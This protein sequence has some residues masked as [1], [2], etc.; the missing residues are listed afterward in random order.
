MQLTRAQAETTRVHFQ[1]V[2]SRPGKRTLL[3]QFTT[4]KAAYAFIAAKK[5][6]GVDW[7]LY[8]NARTVS[9]HFAT[10]ATRLVASSF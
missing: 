5:G 6:R 9:R 3:T 4:R 8:R 10:T 2:L 7:A 1:V